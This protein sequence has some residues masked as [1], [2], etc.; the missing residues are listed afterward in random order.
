MMSV[1]QLGL[2]VAL[3]I[4]IANLAVQT[5]ALGADGVA[6]PNMTGSAVGT[7]EPMTIDLASALRLA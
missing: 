5:G 2:N 4:A 7:S 6:S 3:G 1:K